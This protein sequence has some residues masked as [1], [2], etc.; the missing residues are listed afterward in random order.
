MYMYMYILTSVLFTIHYSL[1]TIYLQYV[2]G[3][4]FNIVIYNISIYFRL[5]LKIKV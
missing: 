2:Y 1:F 3:T 4:Y 5:N